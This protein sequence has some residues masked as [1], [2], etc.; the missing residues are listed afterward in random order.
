MKQ[1]NGCHIQ[2]TYNVYNQRVTNS[3]IIYT[4]KIFP[5]IEMLWLPILPNYIHFSYHY[6]LTSIIKLKEIDELLAAT[7][8]LKHLQQY[9]LHNCTENVSLLHSH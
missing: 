5:T 9:T 8:L 4:L 3:F 6:L 7:L 1:N 2:V